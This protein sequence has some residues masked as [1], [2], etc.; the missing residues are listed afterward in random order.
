MVAEVDLGRKLFVWNSPKNN[1]ENSQE[2]IKFSRK[3]HR[4]A[5]FCLSNTLSIS[6]GILEKIS[7]PGY[8]G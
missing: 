7:P 3:S 6:A 5:F 8:L 4:F 2:I 1:P